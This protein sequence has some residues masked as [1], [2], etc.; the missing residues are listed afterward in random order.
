MGPE[1]KNCQSCE[2]SFP[3]EP[4]D[5]DFYRKI[6]VP[7]PT[8]CPE[9]R[10]RRRMAFRNERTLHKRP[11]NAPGHT[12]EILSIYSPE[13]PHTVY[14]FDHWWSDAWDPMTYG[15][16]YDFSKPFFAQWRELRDRVPLIALSNSRAVNSEYCNV[17]D[18]SKDCYLISA[19]YENEKVIYANRVSYSS[20][21][22]D[23]YILNKGEL[24]YED[25]ACSNSYKLLFSFQSRNCSNSA[26]LY[27]CENCH[28]CF[29]C[30]GQRN[31]SYCFFNQQLTKEEYS[32]KIREYD[33]SSYAAI[34]KARQ[35]FR[36]VYLSAVH[37][38]S[39]IVSSPGCTGDNVAESHNARWCFDMRLTEN[40]K[41]CNWGGFGLKDSYDA[42]PG[43]GDNSDLLYED[44]DIVRDSR[45]FFSSVVYDSHDV[46]YSMNCYNSS[47]LFGCIGLRK[48]QYC[49]LNRQYAKEEYTSL[50]GQIVEQ[51]K[52]VP[53]QDSVGQ[54]YGYGEFLPPELSPFGFN[55]TVASELLPLDRAT[56][57][58]RGYRWRDVSAKDYAVTCRAEELPDFLGQTDQNILTQII[59]CTHAGQCADQ[60][61]KAFKITP[62]ELEFHR[63]INVA[64]PRL[65]FN[66][67]HHARIA[68]RN[69]IN[70]WPRS[71]VCG[72]G[73]H[74]NSTVHAHSDA[75]CPNKFESPYPPDRPEIIYCEQCYNAEVA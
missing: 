11:C 32:E 21:S 27:D 29:G 67:R 45:V 38:Y 5:L 37:K 49:I 9:C 42:G 43:I 1:T 4:E 26:F 40:S 34:L 17:N 75:A 23:C 24:C 41:F 48:K 14:D 69:P 51:M 70:L 25:V 19:A 56:A 33:L 31:K 35:K 53:H 36:E 6:G 7:P 68:E 64:L 12:E 46:Q 62:A 74:T 20:E 8:W 59:G 58:A 28:S 57:V 13:D 16:E 63:K 44:F 60:C 22:A 50:V 65:C 61:T 39:A 66:C 72:T 2:N 54:K 10:A 52:T 30:A 73:R 47:D 55:E 71:C 18:K 3:V 15:R